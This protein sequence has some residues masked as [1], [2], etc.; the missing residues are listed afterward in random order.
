MCLA[1]RCRAPKVPE[2]R[3]I[4]AMCKYTYMTTLSP[5]NSRLESAARMPISS[6]PGLGLFI[7][8]NC[9]A[10]CSTGSFLA[11]RSRFRI[12]PPCVDLTGPV[13]HVEQSLVCCDRRF[14]NE[15]MSSL[16]G[17]THALLISYL[18][19]L[20]RTFTLHFNRSCKILIDLEPQVV[21]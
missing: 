4:D 16:V 5:R 12:Q 6:G 14:A 18:L 17:T 15:L 10:T 3:C 9:P 2:M 13:D 8:L 21:V 20:R 11:T 1:N 7:T 19:E